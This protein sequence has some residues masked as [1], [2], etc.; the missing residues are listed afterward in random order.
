MRVH[1]GQLRDR[2]NMHGLNLASN[3]RAPTIPSFSTPQLRIS[4]A[5]GLED[6]R[7]HESSRQAWR[8]RRVETLAFPTLGGSQS[9]GYDT[10]RWLGERGVTEAISYLRG[11]RVLTGV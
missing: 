10:P 3:W 5:A 6:Q 4:T 11:T 1:A 9:A 8:Q 2:L 7:Q